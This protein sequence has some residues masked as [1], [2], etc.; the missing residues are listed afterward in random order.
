MSIIIVVDLELCM[1]AMAASFRMFQALALDRGLPDWRTVSKV[2]N[3][4][5]VAYVIAYKMQVNKR[6][7][8]PTASLVLTIHFSF[9]LRLISIGAP[10][11]LNDVI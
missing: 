3:H 2:M 6:T 7:K 1:A 11:A 8:V 4:I 10:I 5:V 9:L